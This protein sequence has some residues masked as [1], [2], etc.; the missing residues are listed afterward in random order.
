MVLETRQCEEAPHA[1][2][3]I[4]D[5]LH[6]LLLRVAQECAEQVGIGVVD[7]LDEERVREL[8]STREL[9]DELV[10]AVQPLQEHGTAL[11]L[12]LATGSVATTV[13]KFVSK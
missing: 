11:V 4:V 1:E 8:E 13:G 2:R 5:P 9:L 6:P 7:E 12:I 3:V 10:D